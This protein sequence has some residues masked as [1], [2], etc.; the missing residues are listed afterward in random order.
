[1]SQCV[2]FLLESNELKNANIAENSGNFINLI[3]QDTSI[4]EIIFDGHEL[5]LHDNENEV[6]ID[7]HI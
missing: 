2:L 5:D 4:T 7:C 3:V 6:N 1:M